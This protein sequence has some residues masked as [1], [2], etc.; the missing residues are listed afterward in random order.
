MSA[1]RIETNGPLVT[2]R[3]DKARGNSIDEP[4]VEEIVDVCRQV[5]ADRDVRGVLLASAHPKLFCPGLDLVTL[6][7]YDRPALE[8]FLGRFAEAL[9]ALYT[10]R[11]PMEIGRAHV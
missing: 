1:I 10:L 6:L 7:E 3:L 9:W 2:L 8:R 11:P 4:L 5:S